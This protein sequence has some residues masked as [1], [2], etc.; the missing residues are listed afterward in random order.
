LITNKQKSSLTISAKSPK[1]SK[2]QHMI[3]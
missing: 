1:I 2:Q 3:V